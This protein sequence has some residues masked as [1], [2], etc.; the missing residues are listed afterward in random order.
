MSDTTTAEIE[1]DVN[2][3]L[4][5]H[6]QNQGIKKKYA[7]SRAVEDWLDEKEAGGEK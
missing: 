2:D 1:R 3:R 5:Q 7:V 6:L 4:D